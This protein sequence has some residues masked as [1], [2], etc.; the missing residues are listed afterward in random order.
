MAAVQCSK[1]TQPYRRIVGRHTG[2]CEDHYHAWV[3]SRC[4]QQIETYVGMASYQSRCSRKAQANGR[5]WQH[6]KSV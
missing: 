1:C 4:K 6:D 2:L 3:A 5:C